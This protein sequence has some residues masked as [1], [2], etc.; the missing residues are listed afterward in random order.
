MV[1]QIGFICKRYNDNQ[2]DWTPD[3][4]VSL[5]AEMLIGDDDKPKPWVKP[6]STNPYMMVTR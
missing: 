2:A 5:Y 4:A 1:I 3:T 6:D